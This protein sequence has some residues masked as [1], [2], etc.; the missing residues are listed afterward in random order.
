[1]DK[2]GKL[3]QFFLFVRKQGVKSVGESNVTCHKVGPDKMKGIKK[4][5]TTLEAVGFL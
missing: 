1:M 4:R 5:K 2:Q 3:W